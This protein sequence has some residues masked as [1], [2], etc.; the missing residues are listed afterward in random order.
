MGRCLGFLRRA[1]GVYSDC[2]YP[3]R[4]RAAAMHPEQPGR[5]PPRTRRPNRCSLQTR[6]HARATAW[7]STRLLWR[8]TG[9]RRRAHSTRPPAA[10]AGNIGSDLQQYRTQTQTQHPGA[11]HLVAARR[12]RADLR[13]PMASGPQIRV[14]AGE[15]R[16][17]DPRWRA[18][19]RS[20][21]AAAGE[22][23]RTSDPRWRRTRPAP[24]R[25]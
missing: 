12:G 13:S 5:K 19:L 9:W 8:S 3:A 17:S 22:G 25:G 10:T 11:R 7:T 15:E 18:D 6:T 21:V 20:W 14:A 23:E 16:T 2:Q 24:R 1:C 4:D